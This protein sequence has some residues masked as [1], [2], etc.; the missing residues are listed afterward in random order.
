[1]LFKVIGYNPKI[2]YIKKNLSGTPRKLLDISLAKKYGWKYKSNIFKSL[3]KNLWFLFRRRFFKMLVGFFL[4]SQFYIQFMVI[5]MYI[6][7]IF[8][9]IM[10]V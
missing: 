9:M 10:I 5:L 2:K 7:N 1:M 3:S 4:T 6:K 8:W